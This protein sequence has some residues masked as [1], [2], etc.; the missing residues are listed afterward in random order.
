MPI[1]PGDIEDLV[2]TGVVRGPASGAM[3]MAIQLAAERQI[4]VGLAGT[5]AGV[6]SGDPVSTNFGMYGPPGPP[7]APVPQTGTGLTAD[8][9]A[10]LD[11]S[12]T[13]YDP[14]NTIKITAP[15]AKD[16]RNMTKAEIAAA[17]VV[18]G[19]AAALAAGTLVT[20]A[21]LTPSASQNGNGSW[22]E[23]L[24]STVSSISPGWG[25]AL[26]IVGAGAAGLGLGHLLGQSGTKGGSNMAVSTGSAL[27]P[28]GFGLQGPGIPEP[29]PGTFSK[30]WRI[31]S[32]DRDGR[33]IY[34]YFWKLYN[35]SI[36]YYSTSGKVGNYKPKKPVAVI[37][38]GGKMS[39]QDFLKADRY[40]DRFT[41]RIAKRS[42]RLKIQ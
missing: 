15:P 7:P 13:R 6:R 38:Q 35:G 32:E 31:E 25:T 14:S 34:T 17:S 19:S 22:W 26:G 39:M 33:K 23:N 40:L 18:G 20:G 1:T 24:T 41:R 2:R 4:P 30:E 3:P 5:F 16:W 29:L 12:R 27:S 42:K 10:V 37:M 9:L 28:G 21:K 8:K 11:R 36:T